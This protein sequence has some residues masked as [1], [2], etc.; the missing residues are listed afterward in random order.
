MQ[1]ISYILD[2]W[3]LITSVSVVIFLMFMLLRCVPETWE[4]VIENI[5]SILE[6]L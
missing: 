1:I 6:C 5:C 4:A 3:V 2:H